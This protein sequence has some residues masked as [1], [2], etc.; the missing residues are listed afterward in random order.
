MSPSVLRVVKM[1]I[2][3]LWHVMSYRRVDISA[4]EELVASIFR[5]KE[6]AARE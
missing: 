5:I 4:S 2:T 3:I 1:R 6:Y